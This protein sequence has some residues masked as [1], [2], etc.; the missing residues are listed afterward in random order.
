MRC[1]SWSGV[2]AGAE[3]ALL[4]AGEDDDAHRGVLEADAVERV[5]QLDI[6]AEIVGVELELV[7][8]R[9]TALFRHVELQRGDRPLGREFPM[10]VASGIGVEVDQARLSPWLSLLSVRAHTPPPP[11]GG[12][13]AGIAHA[14]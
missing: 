13:V 1:F 2:N 12:Q 9:E 10:T 8:G 14:G 7:T 4:G 6:D 3:Q 11:H 5:G